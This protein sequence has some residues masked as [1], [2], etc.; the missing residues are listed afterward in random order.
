MTPTQNYLTQLKGKP[1]SELR[2]GPVVFRTDSN[3]NIAVQ[4]EESS[5]KEQLIHDA[6]HLLYFSTNAQKIY[7]GSKADS[8][9]NYFEKNINPSCSIEPIEFHFE[10]IDPS[11][12]RAFS[13]ILKAKITKEDSLQLTAHKVIQAIKCL[14]ETRALKEQTIPYE[15]WK[16]YLFLSAGF[17]VLFS[18]N[19]SFPA[20]DLRQQLRPLLHLKFSHSVELLWKWVDQFYAI[21]NA[22]LNGEYSPNLLFLS[23]PNIKTPLLLIAEKLLIYSIYDLLFKNKLVEGSS[24]TLSTPDDFKIIHPERVLVY[25]WTESN[26]EKKL[27][28]LSLSHSDEQELQML[29]KIKE[30]HGYLRTAGLNLSAK[31]I[32]QEEKINKP[33]S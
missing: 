23:N 12:I 17:E 24:G 26:I 20:S 10:E 33:R 22:A 16:D 7:Y 9:A 15:D 30:M 11:L 29:V 13:L 27:T 25:F 19:P 5:F 4:S 21:R 18:L 6:I 3:R 32:F 28:L 2:I 1:G 14:N 31:E 8:L